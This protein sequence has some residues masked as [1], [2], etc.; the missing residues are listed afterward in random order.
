[1][2][3]FYLYTDTNSRRQVMDD[4]AAR[5][6]GETY[7]LWVFNLYFNTD[8][9]LL[10]DETYATIGKYPHNYFKLNYN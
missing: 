10:P 1:M 4:P 8:F 3:V 2:K 5:S 9:K 6:S 7:L